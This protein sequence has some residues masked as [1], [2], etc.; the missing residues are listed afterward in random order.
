MKETGV[1]N[2]IRTTLKSLS[3]YTRFCILAIVGIIIFI[4][5]FIINPELIYSEITDKYYWFHLSIILLGLCVVLVAV[6][7]KEKIPYPFGWPDVLIGIITI[8]LVCSYQWQLTVAYDRL[9]FDLQLICYWFLL[10]ISFA[11]T[12]RLAKFYLLILIYTGFLFAIWGL[13]Q[14]CFKFSSRLAFTLTETF[15]NSGPYSGFL[16]IMAP[17]LL[18]RILKYRIYRKT[19][20][21]DK[22]CILY[23]FFL[24]TLIILVTILLVGMSYF[25]WLAAS[26]SCTWVLWMRLPDAKKMWEYWT[27]HR[28]RMIWILL[29]ASIVTVTAF[30]GIF[31][32]KRDLV[33]ERFLMWKITASVIAENPMKGTGIGGFPEAYIQA[34]EAY[35]ALGKASDTEK[36]V[37]GI[38]EYAFNEYL[39]LWLELGLA[40]IVSF[41]GLVC[42][43]FYRAM[44]KRQTAACGALIALGIF[45]LSS[46]PLQLPS[47][48][49]VLVVLLAVMNVKHPYVPQ[50]ENKYIRSVVIG[51]LAFV[52]L[53]VSVAL[54]CQ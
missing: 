12:P 51:F 30:T 48:G 14:L 42:I 3:D 10:R 2:I 28:K 32:L 33:N 6:T 7:R 19:D 36:R 34:Q 8:T 5:V 23:Y 18:D 29:T 11:I 17:A 50:K 22:Y 24:V 16:A 4:S 53:C 46:Y 20:L 35:F 49:I 27:K 37:V 44:K 25:A 40:G 43:S 45:A 26:I 15:Y 21:A 52:I 13:I 38:P 1:I 54:F 47:F 9:I 41:I 31:L 39:Q